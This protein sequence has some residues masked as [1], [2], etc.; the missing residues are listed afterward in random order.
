MEV[1][2]FGITSQDIKIIDTK[3]ELQKRYLL[4]KFC[5]FEDE[6][7]SILDFTFSANLNQKKYLQK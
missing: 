1:A 5:D 4:N 7:K 2:M 6:L 3:I